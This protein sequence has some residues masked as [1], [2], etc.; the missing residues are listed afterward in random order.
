MVSAGASSQGVPRGKPPSIPLSLG[1]EL[2]S[3][4]RAQGGAGRALG[5][6]L[7]AWEPLLWQRLWEKRRPGAAQPHCGDQGAVSTMAWT[8][9]LLVLLSHCTG[10]DRPRGPG[11]SPQPA[12]APMAQTPG[13]FPPAPAPSPTCVC[14]CRFPLPACADSAALPLYISW[15]ISQTH[16]HP[17]QWVQCCQLYYILVPA[18]AREPSPVP[19]EV[20]VR[21]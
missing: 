21:L 7:F 9:L 3:S 10:R 13:I 20:Q 5:G 16:L 15:S 2:S 14:V 19:P 17:E 4:T 8:P 1:C 11:L 12:S 6:H 18:E